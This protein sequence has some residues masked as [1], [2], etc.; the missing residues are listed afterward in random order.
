M[1]IAEASRIFALA[2]VAAVT[3]ATPFAWA[4]TAAPAAD[5]AAPA[6]DTAAAAEPPP[7]IAPNA[8]TFM[9]ENGLE[10]LVIPDHRAPVVTQMVWYKAGS[11]DEERGHSGIAHFLEHLMFKGTTKHPDG[12]LAAIIAQYG[13]SQNAFTTQDYTVYHQ[14]IAKQHLREVM[15]LESDRMENLVLSDD[16]VNSE[17][18]V[19]L[20]ERRMRIDNDPGSQLGEA[21]TAALFQNSPY[22]MPVIGWASE[23]AALTREDA[24]AWYDRYYTP[25]NAILILAGDID[26]A[27]ARSL[28]E[29]FYGPLPRRAEPPPRVR[30]Q[31]PP[32]LAARVVTLADPR[33]TQPSI[34]RR[35]LAPSDIQSPRE[36]LALQVLGDILGGGTSSRFYSTLVQGKAVAT[37]AGAR[38][39][40][41][42]IDHGHIYL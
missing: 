4:E 5:T 30:A 36:A 34:S 29:E 24:I 1:R 20:E 28:A 11:A 33:V 2:L 22:G 35:Y 32:P 6:A 7:V 9:L 15:E 40:R 38:D 12:E 18:E 27:T 31:E 19:I 26:E 3:V 37:A 21:I 10:V 13:G 23:M 25:N 39:S 17:R 41:P 16:V 14:T 42:P 8:T